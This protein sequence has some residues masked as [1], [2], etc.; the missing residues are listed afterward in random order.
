[1]IIKKLL[2]LLVMIPFIGFSQEKQQIEATPKSTVMVEYFNSGYGVDRRDY[3]YVDF[4]RDKI[5]EGLKT[6]YRVNVSD[7]ADFMELRNSDPG[8][9]NMVEFMRNR[10]NAMNELGADLSIE[11]EV[12]SVGAVR[13]KDVWRPA[14]AFT[15]RIINTDGGRTAYTYKITEK[16]LSYGATSPDKAISDAI[17]TAAGWFR[18]FVMKSLKIYG[19]VLEVVSMKNADEVK[20][21]SLNVGPSN[22]AYK[23]SK[24]EVHIVLGEQ[25]TK[26]IGNVKIESIEGDQR[27]I[28]KVS[29]GGKDIK[30]AIDEGKTLMI[31]SENPGF[32]D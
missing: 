20:E 21:V 28:A 31:I 6:S 24:F 23:N 22:A 25:S 18:T 19:Q 7:V 5:I 3:H 1:M 9:Q 11:C 2:L 17:V 14:L 30:N 4:L 13:D 29:K 26:K 27:S 16:D 32:F 12:S 8:Q 15:I 10:Y